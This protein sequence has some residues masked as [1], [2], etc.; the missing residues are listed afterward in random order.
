MLKSI[1]ATNTE[2][3]VVV[4]KNKEVPNNCMERFKDGTFVIKELDVVDPF[5]GIQ[6]QYPSLL[7]HLMNRLDIFSLTEYK[8]I[9][10]FE[11]YTHILYNMDEIFACGYFCG[12]D[13]QPIVILF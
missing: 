10:I 1:I 11:P 7:Q 2:A 4:I 8:R 13:Q 5:I 9:A 3:D 6:T 12:V